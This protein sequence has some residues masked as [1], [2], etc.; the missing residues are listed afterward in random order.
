MTRIELENIIDRAPFSQQA[1]DGLMRVSAPMM[2]AFWLAQGF[3]VF[4]QRSS[5]I[6]CRNNNNVRCCSDCSETFA[7]AAAADRHELVRCTFAKSRTYSINLCSIIMLQ[8]RFSRA[9]FCSVSVLANNPNDSQPCIIG[10][11]NSR[12]RYASVWRNPFAL[13]DH[14]KTG[15]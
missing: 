12:A 1:N 10:V 6:I 15:S 14:S 8:R 13:Q 2:I 5:A 3:K 7:A 9:Y 11:H 4:H